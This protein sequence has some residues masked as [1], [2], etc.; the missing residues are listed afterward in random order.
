MVLGWRDEPELPAVIPVAGSV[1]VGSVGVFVLREVLLEFELL[2]V[3][4]PNA[5]Y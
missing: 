5:G 3:A 2:L 1:V 4:S